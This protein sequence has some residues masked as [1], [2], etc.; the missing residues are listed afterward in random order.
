VE[1]TDRQAATGNQCP[2]V[3]RDL[4][5]P[6]RRDDLHPRLIPFGRG[7]LTVI[8]PKGNRQK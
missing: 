5:R 6:T 1:A 3:E 4:S 8:P 7:A 2:H